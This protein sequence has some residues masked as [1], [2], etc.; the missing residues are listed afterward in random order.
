MKSIVI[1]AAILIVFNYATCKKDCYG[2]N[3]SFETMFNVY[4][5]KEIV[6]LGDTIWLSMKQSVE[7]KDELTGKVIDFSNAAIGISIQFIKFNFY[8]KDSLPERAANYFKI[9][10][11]EGILIDDSYF[12][13]DLVL[14]F[15]YVEKDKHY[16]FKIGLIA[17]EPG[18]Y[19][20]AT[21]D[22]KIYRKNDLCTKAGLTQTYFNTIDT[23]LHIYEEHRPEYTPSFY[24]QKHMY[25]FRVR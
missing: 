2:S 5:N 1:M 8:H 13:K 19:A 15:Y 9:I 12:P 18:N 3:Y 22:D 24:E 16:L 14:P 11:R 23:H 17:K 21:S 7:M 25:F 6:N 4:P 20:F 10:V